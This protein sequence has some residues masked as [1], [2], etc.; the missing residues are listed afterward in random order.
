MTRTR[1]SLIMA[2]L[3]SLALAGGT[4]PAG[5][6]EVGAPFVTIDAAPEGVA[7]TVDEHLQGIEFDNTRPLAAGA[8]GSL[9]L[10]LSDDEY[11]CTWTTAMNSGV[12]DWIGVA[13]R[14]H[15]EPNPE[16]LEQCPA[17]QTKVTTAT[18]AGA[19]ALIVVNFE[20]APTAGAAA[21]E[22]PAL[23]IGNADGERLIS[24]LDPANSDAVKVT[25]ASLDPNTFLPPSPVA[26]T[27]IISLDATGDAAAVT[28]SGR[29]IFGGNIPAVVGED[30]AGDVPF[31]AVL[32]LDITEVRIGQPDPNSGDLSFE[33]DFTDLPATGGVP[34][35]V[36][37][38]WSFAV[39]TG[40]GVPKQLEIDGKFTDVAR[41]QSQST[42]AFFLRGNCVTENN[43]TTCEDV[44]EL[45]TVMDG[46]INRITV[47]VPKTVL[48]D[49]VGAPLEGASIGAGDQCEGISS[50][51]AAYFTLC[52]G[53]GANTGDVVL[54]DGT[55][56]VASATA[57]MGIVPAGAP[58]EFT[59]PAEI[60]SAGRFSGTL[61][62]SGLAPGSYDVHIRT[63]YG[64]NCDTGTTTITI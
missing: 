9:P 16:G 27:R 6:Q 44:A 61:D 12:Q 4:L 35:H 62:T 13:R 32:G 37:Y 22:I 14:G 56:E 46:A 5:A 1:H 63:C 20:A 36:R 48:E 25:L 47:T 50:K 49:D 40:S 34:E 53:V 43:V 23:M 24:S 29:A 31:P 54:Q 60:D 10:F 3:L 15:T 45:P 26:A 55:Y 17:F 28:V 42:P 8:V 64:T 18:A 39:D 21:G 30:P 38:Q 58:A 59:D 57:E 41:R 52:G 11:G 2:A 33:L 19:S 7:V 51:L